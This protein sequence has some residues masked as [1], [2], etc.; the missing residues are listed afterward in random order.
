MSWFSKATG[1]HSKKMFHGVTLGKALPYVAGA[2]ALALLGPGIAAGLGKASLGSLGAGLST[3]G[4]GAGALKYLPA[5]S[6]AAGLFGGGGSNGATAGMQDAINNKN[7]IANLYKSE[8]ANDTAPSLVPVEF[9]HVKDIE[10]A[11]NMNT[12]ANYAPKADL[13]YSS[14]YSNAVNDWK[15]NKMN[16][17]ARLAAM[18]NPQDYSGLYSAQRD[19]N[20]DYLSSLTT[21]GTFL[22]GLGGGK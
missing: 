7:E 13:A 12:Y 11:R 6:A 4:I 22:G 8:L 18:Y 3:K 1:I 2:G 21:L 19:S 9:Q 5:I 17:L 10:A 16:N 14:N 20:K 15:N